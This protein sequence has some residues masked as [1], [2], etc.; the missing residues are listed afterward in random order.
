MAAFLGALLL[1]VPG[2]A[3]AP[4]KARSS[5]VTVRITGQEW[6]W[7][8]PWAKQPPWTRTLTALVVPGKRLLVTSPA[9]G[10]QLLIEVQKMGRDQHAARPSSS[11]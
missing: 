9:M 8:T 6:N 3:A 4:V 2:S 5:V 10:N 1:A 11:T 7:K